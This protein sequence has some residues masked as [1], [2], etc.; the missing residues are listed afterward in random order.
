VYCFGDPILNGTGWSGD[1]TSADWHRQGYSATLAQRV[2]YDDSVNVLQSLGCHT[3]KAE[4]RPADLD[5]NGG[6]ANQRAQ[7]IATDQFMA[8]SGQP[9]F[10]IK[11]GQ[12]HWYGF[13]F[14]TNPGYVPHYD[15]VFGGWNTIQ[16]F[17]NSAINGVWGPLAPIELAVTTIAPSSSEWTCQNGSSAW[18]NTRLA[19]PRLL[20]MVEGGD[21]N[22]P[23]WPN[24]GPTLTCRRYLGP[25]FQAGHLYRVQMKITWGAHK[26][27]SLQVWIDGSKYVDVAGISDMW[28]SGSTVDAGMYAE[29][30]NYRYYDTTLPTNDVYFGGFITGSTQADVAVP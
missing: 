19:T 13:A 23:S 20:I 21:Q 6:T 8:Q 25:G 5:A 26:D 18:Q 28:Y 14:A 2:V 15:P 4:I 29:L 1:V 17:H 10:G 11:E 16:A 30:T 22:D 27:G 7:V 24:D 9:S 12:T 3:I